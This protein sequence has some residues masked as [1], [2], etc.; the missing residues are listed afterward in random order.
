M[1]AGAREI[2][3]EGVILPPL[4]L[5]PEVERLLLANVRTPEVRRGD[6]AAQR[7]AVERGGE[8]LRAL[9][10]RYGGETVRAAAR[11]LIEY[12]E[13]RTRAALAKV[14]ATG[15]RA[16]DWLEGDGVDDVDLPIAVR[17]DI[18]DGVFN[19]DFAG[20]DPAARGNAHCTLAVTRA[21]VLLVSTTLL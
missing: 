21:A 8:G 13:R 3:A 18:R 9:V 15:L 2:F 16:T 20:T 7:A 6:L 11:D 17:V 5:T 14:A 10:A 12:A 1:R 19:A 4:L